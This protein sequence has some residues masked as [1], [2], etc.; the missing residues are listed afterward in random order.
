LLKGVSAALR[1]SVL[2]ALPP[3]AAQRQLKAA[4]HLLGRIER[5]WDRLPGYLE[6]D[7]ADMRQTIGAVIGAMV[8]AGAEVPVS[9]AALPE[10]APPADD[11][12]AWA[13]SALVADHAL[14]LQAATN[15]ELQRGLLQL[16]SWLLASGHRAANDPSDGPLSGLYTRMIEREMRALATEDSGT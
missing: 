10:C 4:L 16:E 7:N 5:C 9:I 8:A 14:A 11:V 13:D 12:R 1:E 15:I 6:D 3:G 2:P